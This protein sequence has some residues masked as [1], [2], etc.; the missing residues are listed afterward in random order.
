MR[1]SDRIILGQIGAPHGVRGQVRIKPFTADPLALG[2]YGPL[3]DAK[4]NRFDITDARL[5]KAMLVVTFKQVTTREAA[6]TLNGTELGVAR[7][8]LPDEALEDDEFYVEDLVGLT[9]L[10]EAGDKIG[11]VTAVHNFGADDIIEVRLAK[12]GKSE[13]YPFTMETVPELDLDAGTLIL[14]PPGEVIAQESS[15]P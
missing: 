1:S 14:I 15:E 4:G 10:D 9:C 5:A 11:S 13:M 12:T 8:Q 3:Y 2:D 6:E 7:D